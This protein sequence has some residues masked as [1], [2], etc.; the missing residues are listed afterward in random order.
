LTC[1]VRKYKIESEIE[2][3]HTTFASSC[4]DM[5]VLIPNRQS[6]TRFRVRWHNYRVFPQ[7]RLAAASIHI[8]EYVDNIKREREREDVCVRE[9]M[10]GRAPIYIY[11]YIHILY[12][13]T[14]ADRPT[15][16]R[17]ER[18][19]RTTEVRI[20]LLATHELETPRT[21]AYEQCTNKPCRFNPHYFRTR[22]RIGWWRTNCRAC[23]L[24]DSVGH[25]QSIQKKKQA[26]KAHK[27]SGRPP[28]VGTQCMG[29]A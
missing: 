26:Q 5:C 6:I 9:R 20:Q 16:T 3:P 29:G 2:R 1:C 24:L 19:E 21:H 25:I 18:K 12:V 27:R 28:L 22:K 7:M 15:D 17:T 8:H 13:H 23:F 4:Y 10:C 11:I 14:S